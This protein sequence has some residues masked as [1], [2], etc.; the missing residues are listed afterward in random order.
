MASAERERDEDRQPAAPA[1]A[2]APEDR[3]EDEDDEQDHQPGAAAPAPAA[4]LLRGLEL[5]R[6]LE[7]EVLGV[8]EGERGHGVVDPPPEVAFPERRDHVEVPDP[9]GL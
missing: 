8:L 4:G 9:A 5:P 1:R 7:A 6:E 3:E 2:A